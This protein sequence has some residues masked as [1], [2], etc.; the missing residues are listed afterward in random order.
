MGASAEEGGT[1]VRL[2]SGH[3]LFVHDRGGGHAVLLLHGVGC[4]ADDW[5]GPSQHFRGQF[6]V[7]R[8]DMRGHGRSGSPGGAWR[9]AD[10]IGDLV[11]ILDRLGV[12]RAHVAGF[13]MGGLLAQ[14]LALEHPGRVEKLAIIAASSGRSPEQQAQVEERLAFIRANPPG[15]YFDTYAAKRWFTAAFRESHPEIVAASRRTV[16]AADPA[17][18]AKAYEVLV[19]NDLGPRLHAI[20]HKTLVLTAENDLGAGPKTARDIAAQ[21][22]G[23]HLIILP[24]LRHHIL[25]EAPELVGGILREFF[26]DGD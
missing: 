17:G 13:S 16:A 19:R 22:R 8:T 15:V 11:A 26:S 10:L 9:L 18:Y 3:E 5:I 20:T 12:A 23:S 6:R 1:R 2:G 7:I 25:L 21:I 24:R 4:G 14:G